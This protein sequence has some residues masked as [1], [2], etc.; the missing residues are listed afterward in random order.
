[1]Y[2]FS[3]R[4]PCRQLK[5]NNS[6]GHPP[7][8]PNR[9]GSLIPTPSQ[10]MVRDR[11]IPIGTLCV[12]DDA[13][14]ATEQSFET[15]PTHSSMSF[16]SPPEA[17]PPVPPRILN[18]PP[19]RQARATTNTMTPPPRPLPHKSRSDSAGSVTSSMSFENNFVNNDA[20]RI[21]NNRTMARAAPLPIPPPSVT[22]NNFQNNLCAEV[23][24]GYFLLEQIGF[25]IV[26]FA[27]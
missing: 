1:M 17:T 18:P 25:D 6:L 16:D 2:K 20:L 22:T 14:E 4:I 27:H 12:F 8:R 13:D 19:S 10:L 21:T 3:S 11:D 26:V 24:V 5:P 15:S 9:S 23:G 7:V